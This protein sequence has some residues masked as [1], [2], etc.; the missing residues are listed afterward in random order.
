MKGVDL[1]L[2]RM[3]VALSFDS[4]RLRLG[5]MCA[6]LASGGAAAVRSSV[7]PTPSDVPE[8]GCDAGWFVASP[9]GA[10]IVFPR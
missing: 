7:E 9:S 3:Q 10:H 4:V 5:C 2:V 6:C 1:P 8:V